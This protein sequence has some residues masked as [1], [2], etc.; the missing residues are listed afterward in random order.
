MG[1][2]LP[3]KLSFV[4]KIYLLSVYTFTFK[5]KILLK[6]FFFTVNN[7]ILSWFTKDHR[8]MPKCI[9]LTGFYSINPLSSKELTYAL[10]GPTQQTG[11]IKLTPRKKLLCIVYHWLQPQDTN[12]C[13]RA[14]TATPNF[15]QSVRNTAM[16]VLYSY[17]PPFFEAVM[18]IAEKT[19]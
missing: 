19:L 1:S 7:T 11:A 15:R 13:R 9:L 12:C 8:P 3:T 16:L 10:L 14:I 5:H 4:A 18:K 17:L 6:I 2:Y